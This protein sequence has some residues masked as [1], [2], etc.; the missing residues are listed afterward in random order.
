M[1]ETLIWKGA[2]SQWVNILKYLF[3][4]ILVGVFLYFDLHIALYLIPVL[5]ALYCFLDVST[6][7]YEITTERIIISKGILSRETTFVEFYRLRDTS[8]IQP[9]FLRLVKLS[10]LVFLTSDRETERFEIIAISNAREI[11][12]QIRTAVEI[13]R[14]EKDVRVREY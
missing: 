12:E 1:P 7:N 8:I 6:T 4:A 3:C 14:V 9:F 2:S 10:N 11:R 5:I 13:I